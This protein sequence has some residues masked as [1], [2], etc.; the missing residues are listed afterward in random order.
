MTRTFMRRR[1][2]AGRS[3]LKEIDQVFYFLKPCLRESGVEMAPVCCG[4]T[5]L[6][7][8]GK[9]ALHEC[10]AELLRIHEGP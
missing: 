5:I 7:G 9:R 6:V 1:F 4:S 10:S 8:E 3:W 2:A